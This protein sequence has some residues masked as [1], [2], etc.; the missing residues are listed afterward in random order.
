MIVCMS[1]N[2]AND[3]QE[4]VIVADI[5]NELDIGKWYVYMYIDTLKLTNLNCLF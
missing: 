2:L 1:R 4:R 3:I 5:A